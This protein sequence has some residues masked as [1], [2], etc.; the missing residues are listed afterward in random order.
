MRSH[1]QILNTDQINKYNYKFSLS[2]L[3]SGLKQT[4]GIGTPSF[5]SH[6]YHRPYAWCKTLGLWVMPHQA[7]L[8]GKML[9]PNKQ[10]ERE[11]VNNLCLD[12]ISRK[13][14]D[15]PENE[16][17]DL[18]SKINKD[19]ISEDA[20]VVQRECI[21]ILDKNIAK[22]MFPEI[23]L[24]NETDKHSLISLKELNP[25]APGVFEHKGVAVFAH[26]FFRRS[27]SQ[28]N[29]LNSPFL[30]KIQ[31]LI[32]KDELDLKIAID[33]HSLGLIESYK[34]PIELDFWWGPKFNNN[35]ND[36]PL[37]VSLHKSNEK[38]EFFSGVS[39]TEFWWHRQDG[40]QSLE[41]EEVRAKP[42]YGFSNER[43]EEL[44]GCRYVHSMI[45]KEG[46]AYHL[47]GAVRVY[48]EEQF[49]NRLDVDITKAGKN[50]EYYKVWRI[51]GPIDISLWKSL[52]SDFYKDN[53]LIGEYFLG[54][55]REIQ[56]IQEIQ[57]ENILS[58]LQQD[59]TEE[60]GIQ[61]Y[62]SYHEL[63]EKEVAENEDIFVCPVEF[64]NYSDG[65]LRFIDF[66]AL[67][68]LKILRSSTNFKLKLP[69]DTKY[70]A[71]EDYNINLPLVICKNGNH[72]ENAS[73]IFN[74]VKIFINS[75]NNIE[76]R[77]VTLAIG[78][79]YEEV[80]A[81]FSL[82]FKPKSFLQYI[83]NNE[84]TFP[85]CFDDIGE[86]IEE[87]QNLLSITFKDTKTSFSDSGYLSDIGQFTVNREYLPADMIVLE[88]EFSLRIHESNVE[89][90][91]LIQSGKMIAAPVFLI[92][93]VECESCESNYLTCECNLIM[94]LKK[95]NSYEPVSMFWSRKNTFID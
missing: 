70:L 59:F 26:R 13:I 36:I 8:I 54:E 95:M 15:V 94:T 9:I 4:W 22:K 90:I 84:I 51:D 28:F 7:A 85:N 67:D 57:E 78:I 1:I 38:E 31:N 24:G 65:G 52:I 19:F 74:S 80:L 3:E 75:L 61:A 21:S 34:S 88:K 62:L 12:F 76:N 47:D 60:D 48:N 33:P 56:E 23:F 30:E 91:N 27:L 92:D 11:L 44:Y 20:I 73:K 82:I 83:Q 86:W 37:G 43:S 32:S 55:K 63:I 10:E 41:C 89:I 14:Q 25:I 29:N 50:T 45:N 87:F 39:R 16:K 40:I 18:L 81:K 42:S 64:L 71:F 66:Y 77:I 46:K 2:T 17:A 6:D 68:F 79:E 53:H 35:L 49:I 5:I 58:Y 93:E 72:V 69:Q